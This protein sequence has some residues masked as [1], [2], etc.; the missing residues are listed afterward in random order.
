VMEIFSPNT[1]FKKVDLP[2]FGLP[3]MAT[4]PLRKL[5]LI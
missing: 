5:S 1:L 2:V 3:M 4:K